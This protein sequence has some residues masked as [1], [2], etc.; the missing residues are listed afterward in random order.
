MAELFYV[1]GG[2][3]AGAGAA[4]AASRAGYRVVV[5]EAF[6][7][8]AFKPCGNAVPVLD[9]L[10]LRVPR[11]AVLN[12]VR[13]ARVWIDG[14]PVFESR[15]FVEGVEGLVVD[16]A[17]L[18]ES[19]FAD[20]RAEL[21]LGAKYDVRRG[22]A[23]VG[24]EIVDVKTGVFAGGFPYY[25]GEKVPIVQ[26]IV[27]GVR[28]FDLDS[29]EIHYDSSLV[30]YYY[31]FPYGDKLEVG[32]G[33]YASPKELEAMLWRFLEKDKRLRA[34]AVESTRFSQVSV[35]G[36]RP[37]RVKSLAKAGE[38]AGYVFPLTGEGI[39]P[40]ALSGYIAAKAVAEGRDYV[41]EL[42]KSWVHR[43]VARQRRLLEIA[44]SL[45]PGER[46]EL[47]R[48]LSAREH[49]EI[50][51]ASFRLRELL[52]AIIKLA[53]WKPRLALSASR[54]VLA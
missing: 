52:S 37:G 15:G 24:G 28:D 10:V 33:G 34:G 13:R 42:E 14:V 31:V 32:V 36:P 39:R 6:D 53:L 19:A 20:A 40:S 1:V 9:S 48:R 49:A 4:L 21:V 2:G 26:S 50:A 45:S 3:P 44:A 12:R 35:G 5:L 17:L 41:R 38:A 54:A 29:V 27:R 18:L 46:G 16:K 8:L 47:M 51:L 30:G 22:V 25:D 11:E 23:R 7:R 43:A